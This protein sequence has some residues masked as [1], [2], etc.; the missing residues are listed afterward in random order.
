M[1]KSKDRKRAETKQALPDGSL[2]LEVE[3]LIQ[4]GRF[5]D[6]VKQA[7]M[8]YRD[9]GTPE[10]H[11]L[12]ER[13]YFLRAQQL[14]REAM[15]TS[16]VE[17]A[18]HLLDFGVT[19]PSLPAELV[20][21]LLAIG[22]SG[23]AMAM[24]E[25]LESPEAR[26]SLILTASDQ[27]V[28]NPDRAPASLPEI[29]AGS[30]LVRGALKALDAGDEAGAIDCLREVARSSPFADWR[31]FVRGLAAMRRG[32]A[33]GVAA[34]WDKLDSRRAAFRI[35]RSLRASIGVAT[36]AA[37][38][39]TLSVL[40]IAVFGEPILDRL[41][42]VRR[43]V[44]EE[45]WT[46]ASRLLS[47]LRFSLRKIDPR[48]AER[49]TR[50]LLPPVVK[51]VT[52]SSFK[53]GWRLFDSF[54]RAAEA[55]P[56]D[57]KWNRLRALVWEGP[58]GSPTNAE[59]YWQ[60]YLAD[61]KVLTIL[62]PNERRR[63]QALIWVHMAEQYAGDAAAEPD[64]IFGFRPSARETKHAQKRAID[65]LEESIK[66]DP[67]HLTAYRVLIN[68]YEEWNQSDEAEKA[69]HR[70][71][72]AF[73][74]DF[75][76]LLSLT[77]YHRDNDEPEQGLP[78]LHRA[79][80][81]KPLDDTL[82]KTEWNLRGRLARHHALK[83]RWDEGRA[84]LALAAPLW[85][86]MSDHYAFLG[87][88]AV[89]ELKAGEVD[90]AE[91]IIEAAQLRLAEPLPLWLLILIEGSRY[92]LAKATMDRF[93]HLWQVGLAK[94]G[95]SETA[96]AIAELL[97]NYLAENV[98]YA[99]RD[100]HVKE[101]TD[102]LKRTS[103]IRYRREDLIR[104]CDFLV[105]DPQSKLLLDK[106]VKRGLKNFPDSANFQFMAATIEIEKGPYKSNLRQVRKN[107]EKALELALASSDPKEIELVPDL[108]RILTK[109]PDA[110]SGPFGMPFPGFGGGMPRDLIDLFSQLDID[111]F[112]DADD[113][114]DEF[115]DPPFFG[116]GPRPTPPPSG[117]SRDRPKKKKKKR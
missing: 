112:D 2:R 87:R 86:E 115:D 61:L 17:V 116:D 7:K 106:L 92:K 18:H 104:A 43:L 107:L 26:A 76:T 97:R 1:S 51:A 28:L 49:L 65:C 84:E 98:K 60:A 79:R 95:K 5:K 62:S 34:N 113:D 9:A 103:R 31:Y 55:L 35:A 114:G 53:E 45:S 41:K 40:E 69:A 58:Q 89:F 68:V 46:E 85:P 6:A 39:A 67:A 19:D 27:A 44:A 110:T 117:S 50:V 78:Y 4:K 42:Q 33:E 82:R 102:Y 48:L 93:D 83:H 38:D 74:D 22:M 23:P 80:A 70:L 94:K 29:R 91:E 47:P 111:E 73:P 108:K 21:L 99:G 24:G 77:R 101:V 8:C 90:R 56:I 14:H 54:A 81:I 13:A 15:P 10:N 52:E 109:L 25:R 37:G 11:L 63:A 36:D 59:V 96:G 75:E 105:E 3:R 16:A 20:P 12:L 100:G 72:E 32:D 30:L 71:L 64:D 57:P 66:L 88:K